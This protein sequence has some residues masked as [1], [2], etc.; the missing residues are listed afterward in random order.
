MKTHITILFSI[1]MISACIAYKKS[2]IKRQPTIDDY[3]NGKNGF[4][5]TKV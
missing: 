1:L 2:G 4:G 3:Q 5:N